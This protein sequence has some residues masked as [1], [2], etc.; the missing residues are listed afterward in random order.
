MSVRQGAALV[1]RRVVT[2]YFLRN[3]QGVVCRPISLVFF[4]SSVFILERTGCCQIS[5]TSL[6]SIMSSHIHI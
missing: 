2:V 6:P 4:V 5:L 3:V 1:K